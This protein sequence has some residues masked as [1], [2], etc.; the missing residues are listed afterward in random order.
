MTHPEGHP[1][2]V[3]VAPEHLRIAVALADDRAAFDYAL[4]DLADAAQLIEDAVNEHRA[5]T[6][7]VAELG[8]A[9][10]RVVEAATSVHLCYRLSLVAGLPEG[11][12]EAIFEGA[13]VTA[14]ESE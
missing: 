14:Y 5:P 6:A 13:L 1:D 9:C 3:L 2:T 10:A 8:Q 4:S 12:A 11:Q 7:E